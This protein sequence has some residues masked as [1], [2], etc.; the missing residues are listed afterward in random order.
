MSFTVSYTA[1]LSLLRNYIDQFLCVL[2]HLLLAGLNGSAL[3]SW[4]SDLRQ[5]AEVLKSPSAQ[6]FLYLLVPSLNSTKS[7]VVATG[8][9][10]SVVY[11]LTSVSNQS[12]FIPK[13]V[14]TTK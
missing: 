2:A 1:K 14:D 8:E 12:D 10:N 3:Y 6:E 9:S 11:E 4:R 13:Y 7:H 5:F